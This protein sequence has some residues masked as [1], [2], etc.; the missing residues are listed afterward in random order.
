V[1][2]IAKFVAAQGA[3]RRRTVNKQCRIDELRLVLRSGDA[4]ARRMYQTASRAWDEAGQPDVP[5]ITKWFTE[6]QAGLT[7]PDS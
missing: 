5:L 2:L 6:S 3:K 1:G 7:D 4:D